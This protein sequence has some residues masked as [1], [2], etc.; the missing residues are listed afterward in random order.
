MRRKEAHENDEDKGKG[1]E[2]RGRERKLI[3]YGRKE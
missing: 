3:K 1:K 2:E